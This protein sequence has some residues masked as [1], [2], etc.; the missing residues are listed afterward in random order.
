MTASSRCGIIILQELRVNPTVI[1][2][3]LQKSLSYRQSG[4]VPDLCLLIHVVDWLTVSKRIDP[5]S[6]CQSDSRMRVIFPSE[7][8]LRWGKTSALLVD[9]ITKMC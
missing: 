9:T 8:V 1:I 5:W 6:V 3:L 4:A 2:W 7:L